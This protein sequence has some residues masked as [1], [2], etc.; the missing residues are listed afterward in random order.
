MRA[1]LMRDQRRAQNAYGLLFHV[2]DGSHHLDAA[3]LATSAGMDLRLNN[4]DRTAKLFRALDRFVYIKSRNSSWH[5]YT[6]F[7]QYSLRLIF[8]DVH[9]DFPAVGPAFFLGV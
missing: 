9:A 4:P 7:A 3:G 5:R 2:I 1:G 6:K 8:V